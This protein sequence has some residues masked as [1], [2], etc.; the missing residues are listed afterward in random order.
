MPSD[1]PTGQHVDVNGVSLYVE[2]SGDGPPLVLVHGGTVTSRMWSA[3]RPLL[4]EHFRVITPDT[5]GHGRSTNPTGELTYAAVA[6]D[7]AALIEAL[8]L[9]RPFVG[10]WS[11]G[12]QV[13]LEFGMRHPGAAR[14]LVVGGALYDFKS[15]AYLNSITAMLGS[16]TP[17]NIDF[18]AFEAENVEWI[19]AMREWHMQ[20]DDQWQSVI[21][22][23]LGLWLGYPGLTQAQIASITTPTLVILG[24]RDEVV[25]VQVAVDMLNWLPDAELAILPGHTHGRAFAA[26]DVF[27][28]A[29]VDYLKRH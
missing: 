3:I 8:G 2:E 21:D 18:E 17:D 10:G 5:R 27:V 13:T 22:K 11:D 9:D 28:A 4:A 29:V 1:T 19:A 15:P 25:P 26:P 14:A 6:D 7:V 24:D 23:T 20:R 16:F 12:G